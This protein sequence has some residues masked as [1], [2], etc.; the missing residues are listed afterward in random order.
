MLRETIQ[1]KKLAKNNL[2][3]EIKWMI[4]TKKYEGIFC[5][6]LRDGGAI[7]AN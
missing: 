1:Q 4:S 5:A 7:F 6:F 2:F 3:E